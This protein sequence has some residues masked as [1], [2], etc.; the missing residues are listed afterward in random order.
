[1]TKREHEVLQA[2]FNKL[3]YH[4]EEMDKAFKQLQDL[5]ANEGTGTRWC[6]A[7]QNAEDLKS[8]GKNYDHLYERYLIQGGMYEAILELG[9]DL[10]NL[11]FWK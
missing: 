5:N 4:R 6:S 1:M 11:G 7:K 8:C 10:A 2:R 9:G 3:E